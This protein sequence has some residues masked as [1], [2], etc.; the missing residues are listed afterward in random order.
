MFLQGGI[1]VKRSLDELAA[2]CLRYD[3]LEP[4]RLVRFLLNHWFCYEDHKQ[5]SFSK[6]LRVLLLYVEF[7]WKYCTL[8]LVLISGV[9]T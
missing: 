1:G 3:Y 4:P 7:N 8:C 2:S 6:F 5:Q 9:C